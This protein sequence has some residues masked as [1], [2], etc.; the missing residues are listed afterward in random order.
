MTTTITLPCPDCVTKYCPDVGV[1]IACLA[2]Y[3][4]GHLHGAWIDLEDV[5]AA[6]D[7]RD[8]IAC[9]LATS[10]VPG[11][12]EYAVHDSCGLPACLAGEWLDIDQL[13]DFAETV[14]ELGADDLEAYRLF[15]ANTRQLESVDDFRESY[16]GAHDTCWEFA[17]DLAE[18]QGLIPDTWPGSCIDWE[19]AWRDL[20]DKYWAA[21]EENGP[22]HIF[23]SY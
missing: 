15:C 6:Q 23:A 10:P 12:E 19:R 11:A 20:Q 2:A 22:V 3:N 14:Q 18:E 16:R 21:R 4:S 5:T 7:I 13:A 8:A 1:Y 9:V 17:Y